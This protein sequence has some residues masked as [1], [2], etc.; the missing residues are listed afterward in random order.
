MA[1]EAAANK[2]SG[3]HKWY[4]VALMRLKEVNKK[5]KHLNHAD[6]D[7]LQHLKKAVEIDAKDPFAWHFLGKFFNLKIEMFYKC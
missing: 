4:A 2:N 7:I 1:N 5:D 3:V 6:D